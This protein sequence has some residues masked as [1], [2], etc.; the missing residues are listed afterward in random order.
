[1]PKFASV[2]EFLVVD[3]LMLC[4]ENWLNFHDAKAKM[5]QS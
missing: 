2:K 5:G 1:M 3:L 4:A